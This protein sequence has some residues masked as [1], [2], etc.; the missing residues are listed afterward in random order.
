MA[1]LLSCAPLRSPRDSAPSSTTSAKRR[2]RHTPTCPP[3][4]ALTAT[5]LSDAAEDGGC[6][7][8]SYQQSLLAHGQGYSASS[9]HPGPAAPS[10]L[11]TSISSRPPVRPTLETSART[12]PGQGEAQGGCPAP[13]EV[14]LLHGQRVRHQAL[15]RLLG[16][17]VAGVPPEVVG[18]VV[19][20]LSPQETREGVSCEARVKQKQRQVH[21]LYTNAVGE[22]GDVPSFY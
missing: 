10:G 15:Q 11:P 8:T 20:L 12:G 14:V 19:F 22:K 2:P 18:R 21:A 17:G 5:D 3:P 9:P 16:A 4:P 13:G 1:T 7:E 6:A